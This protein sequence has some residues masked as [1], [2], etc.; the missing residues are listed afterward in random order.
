MTR[1]ALGVWVILAAAQTCRA[2]DPCGSAGTAVDDP[3]CI[4]GFLIEDGAEPG[5]CVCPA[6]PRIWGGIDYL[7]WWIERGPA[8]PLVVTG[9]P[10]DPFPGALDQPGTRNLFGGQGLQYGTFNGLRLT[11]GGWLDSAN[12]L[13]VEAGGFLLERRSVLFTASGNANGQPFLATPFIDA[14]TGKDNVYFISQN[15]ANPAISAMLTGGVTA[16]STTNLWSWEAHGVANLAR[17]RTSS[18]D[19]L[20]GFRQTSLREDLTYLTSVTNLTAGGASSFL[21]T[22]VPPGF[23]V[24][25]FDR[26]ATTNLFNGGQV[27]LRFG[28]TWGVVGIDA[29]GKLAMGAMHESVGIAGAT[30]TNAPFPVTTAVGGIFAQTSNIGSYHR[31]VFAVI[32]EAGL[33]LNLR[34]TPNVTARIGYTFLYLSDVVRPGGQI[35]SHININ[36]VPIDAA[37][38]TPGGPN[39]PAFAWHG[40]GLWA[41]G[42][43]FGLAFAY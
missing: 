36:R 20:F 9:S 37:F 28:S 18:T 6:G 8:P 17:S 32:P 42:I 10:A 11:L 21:G 4:K 26:F 35:D 2:Q 30:G 19:L 13:G 16:Y 43:N 14:L 41:Q 3:C 39:L 22:P 27:G 25:S 31:D 1:A 38:G 5:D 24:N 23:L 15:F 7:M 33:N 12:T 40:T 29:V 34:L